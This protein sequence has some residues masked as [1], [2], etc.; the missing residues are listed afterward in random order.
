MKHKTW[1][2]FASCDCGR[3]ERNMTLREIRQVEQC[4]R[5]KINMNL[6]CKGAL[7]PLKSCPRGEN[8]MIM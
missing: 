6:H 2:A 8:A 1:K 3:F 4:T 7:E 5:R